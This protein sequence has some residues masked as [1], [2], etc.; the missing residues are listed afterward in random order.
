MI[1]TKTKNILLKGLTFASLDEFLIAAIGD[2]AGIIILFS[3][4]T[5]KLKNAFR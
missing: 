4:L 5:V 3:K 1:L 2:V